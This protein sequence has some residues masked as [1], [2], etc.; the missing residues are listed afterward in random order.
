MPKAA[1]Y[2]P[3]E[4][5][6]AKD[7]G[8]TLSIQQCSVCGLVQHN[9]KPVSYF[10]QVITAASLAGKSRQSRLEQMKI[11]VNR[12]GLVGKKV[13]D[14][15]SGKEMLGVIKEAN[16]LA[17]GI[18]GD[19]INKGKIKGGPFDAFIFLN[20]LEHLPKPGHVI[21]N[22]YKNT[23]DHA[24]GFVT[25]PNLEYLLKT[26]CFYE[27]VADHISYFTEKTLRY[28]FESNGF[29]VL[30]CQAIN[31]GCDIALTV[32][33]RKNLELFNQYDAVNSLIKDL[34]NIVAK[35][36]K[37]AVWGAGHRTLAL[38]AL[39]KLKNIEYVIDSAKFK[40]GKFTP[41]THLNIV[42]AEHLLKKELDLVIVMVPGIYP[43]E[44]LKKIKEMNINSKIAIL[45]ENK[46]K[47]I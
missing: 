43:E 1:Q 36:K 39:A 33:K 15:G 7:I 20:Y 44:V 28:A 2:Y 5:E 42:P 35:H 41:I 31:N 13:L 11:F 6:F 8:I 27:F 34:Q 37:V 17:T 23:A 45:A 47:F 30:S 22:I 16:M 4:K 26:K 19:I 12:F 46:I 25:V 24:A 32:K 14:I 10:K 9:L 40:Q 3:A 21:Q 38:L 18:E 29:D